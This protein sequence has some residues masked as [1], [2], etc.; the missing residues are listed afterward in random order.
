[1]EG[2]VK[3]YFTTA[4]TID[5]VS[6]NGIESN[7]VDQPYRMR[8]VSAISSAS[9]GVTEGTVR[10]LIDYVE[11]NGGWLILVFHSIGEPV[12]TMWCSVDNLERIADYALSKN[13]DIKTVADVIRNTK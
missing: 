12:S 9:G 4:R 8:A 7:V 5:Y 2:V 10:T 13:V 6:L 11:Q 1:M 3:K